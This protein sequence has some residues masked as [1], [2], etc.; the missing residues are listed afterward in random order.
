MAGHVPPDPTS[1]PE[2]ERDSR[3]QSPL[4]VEVEIYIEAD[5]TVTFADL[6]AELLP[7]ARQL[8][9]D[10]RLAGKKPAD[11]EPGS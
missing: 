8:D 11:D 9:P 5:G 6:A 2:G 10:F 7:L 1:A 3:R 4:P